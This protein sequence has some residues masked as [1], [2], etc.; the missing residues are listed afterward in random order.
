MN[1]CIHCVF[2]L[3]NRQ[4]F[5]VVN[6]SN[7]SPFGIIRLIKFDKGIYG[8]LSQVSFATFIGGMFGFL[9]VI[10][11][12]IYP[13]IIIHAIIDFVT[14]LD[15]AGLP[16]TQTGFQNTSIE[17]AVLIALLSFPCL[18][19]GLFLMRRYSLVEQQE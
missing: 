17:N 4:N 3:D 19:Y 13:L 2:R 5:Y 8:E 10:T 6:Q 12:R 14:K 9:L 16:V 11:K 7:H 18:L 1:T 15:S